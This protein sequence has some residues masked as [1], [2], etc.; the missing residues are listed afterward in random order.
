MRCCKLSA[1]VRIR[2]H[3]SK[4]D[5]DFKRT[6]FIPPHIIQQHFKVSIREVWWYLFV[7]GFPVFFR[8]LF[9]CVLHQSVHRFFVGIRLFVCVHCRG[10]WVCQVV[11]VVV[12]AI[13]D[14]T[15]SGVFS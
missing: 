9:A 12:V 7:N 10:I 4:T 1:L 6:M 14:G 13:D 11:V 2:E 5:V 8:W 3:T 15:C